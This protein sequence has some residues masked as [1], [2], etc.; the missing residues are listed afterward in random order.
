MLLTIGLR[1]EATTALAA[2]ASRSTPSS[3]G[4]EHDA[5]ASTDHAA[6]S[7]PDT[8]KMG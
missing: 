5:L 7:I 6:T 1:A 4:V 8:L 2:M 3:A